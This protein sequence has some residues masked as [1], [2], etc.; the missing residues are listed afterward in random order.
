M[1]DLDTN[2][3]QLTEYWLNLKSVERFFNVK[4]EKELC[5]VNKNLNFFKIFH[6]LKYGY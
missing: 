2:R 6:D 4:F 1:D 3:T 5:D